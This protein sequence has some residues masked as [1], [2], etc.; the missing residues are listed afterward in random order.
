[1]TSKTLRYL[2]V[3][4]LVFYLV[5][6]AIERHGFE[7]GPMSPI[8]R[9]LTAPILWG[10]ALYGVWRGSVMGR[11]PLYYDRATH[12]RSALA[13]DLQ[14]FLS[15]SP[16]PLVFTLGSLAVQFPGGFFRVSRDVARQLRKRA[17]LLVGAHATD[18]YPDERSADVFVRDYAPFS[19]LFPHAQAIIHHGGIG[20][21]GR[22]LRAGKP[23][24]VVP[25][26]S[27]QFDNAARVVRLD[28]ARSVRLKQ[29]VPNRVAAELSSLLSKPAIPRA[30]PLSAGRFVARMAHKS[31]LA[32]STA[33]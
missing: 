1:M 28:V 23:Q 24:L 21:G 29:H 25:F 16:P 6:V 19:E 10:F 2:A 15:S 9:I 22:A 20:T 12:K 8:D 17:V 13:A 5:A 18:P 11:Q 27:D 30:P 14:E 3:A 32:S 31:P 7:R 4:Y 33:S 26:H